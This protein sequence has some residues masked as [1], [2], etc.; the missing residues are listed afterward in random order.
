MKFYKIV[1]LFQFCLFFLATAAQDERVAMKD[2]E[3]YKEWTKVR[4]ALRVGLGTQSAFYS[5]LGLTM[6]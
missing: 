2:R 4:P 3:G 1:L 6:H 5:E